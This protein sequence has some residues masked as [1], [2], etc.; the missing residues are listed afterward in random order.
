[1]FSNFMLSIFQAFSLDSPLLE[2]FSMAVLDVI[3]SDIMMDMKREYLGFSDPVTSSHLD[4]ALPQSL[5][6]QSF[7][8][9][10]VFMGVVIIA[11]IVSSEVAIMR[12]KSKINVE[13]KQK[14]AEDKIVVENFLIFMTVAAIIAS[15]IFHYA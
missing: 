8:G 11:A 3:E 14:E 5:D 12:R 1:M 2:I 7:I 9:L 4:Q 10:F 15:D 6:V 13:K